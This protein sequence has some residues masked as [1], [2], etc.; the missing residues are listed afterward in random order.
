MKILNAFLTAMLFTISIGLL[1]EDVKEL[2][3]V[4]KPS[5]RKIKYVGRFDSSN[6]AGPKCSWSA[7]NVTIKFTGTAANVKMTSKKGDRWQI[8]V[9]E[10][11]TKVLQMTGSPVL[12]ELASDLP[13]GKH[14]ISLM[15]ATEAHVGTTQILEFQLSKGAKLLQVPPAKHRLEIIGDSI[16]CGYGNEA[17]K[18]EDHFSPA[19]ENAY[20]TYGAIAAREL[21]ADYVCIAWSGKRMWP[22]NTIP[23][24]YG[25][26]IPFDSNSK[27]DAAKWKPE[28]IVINLCTNDFGKETPEED[29]WVNAYKH[30]IAE[31]RNN[32]PKAAIF[33]SIGPMMNDSWPKGK[34]SLSTATGYLKRIVDECNKAGD[35][36]VFFLAFKPQNGSNG[37]GA[38]WHPSAKQHEAMA[39]TLVTTLKETLKW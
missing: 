19:T 29:D 30:F 37:F 15:K 9:D 20:K 12:F 14:T 27:W 18:K 23:E 36:N 24:L 4:V 10:K 38:D 2:P 7:S 25:R 5:N 21:D 13:G 22:K 11:P 34:K 35:K 17:N 28:A 39:Q 3:V 31:L 16:S 8:S 33:C 32:T 1:A 26:I 6:P